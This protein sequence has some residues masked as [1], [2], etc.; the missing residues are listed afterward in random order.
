MSDT[1]ISAV[2]VA[3]AVVVVTTVTV[4][5]WKGLNVAWLRPKKNEAYL[6]RQGLSGTPFT[7]LV[8][9]I[10]REASMVE[11]EKSRP[12]NLTD[13][14]THRVMPLIQQTVKDHG[15]KWFDLNS[16]QISSVF[17]IYALVSVNILCFYGWFLFREDILHVDGTYSECDCDE[18]RTHQRCSKQSLRF[19][20]AASAPNR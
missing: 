8:G 4:W 2:A 9:D 3:A 20:E 6:K 11:Q 13:D 16:K 10:K 1:K 14:Y 17:L 15:K 5:I 19:P 18:T 7:F 12:I